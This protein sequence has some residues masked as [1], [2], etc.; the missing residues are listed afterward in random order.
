MLSTIIARRAIARSN[1]A[2]LSSPSSPL[3]PSFNSALRN[4]AASHPL[5]RQSLHTS[6]CRPFRPTLNYRLSTPVPGEHPQMNPIVQRRQSFGK[7]LWLVGAPG[8]IKWPI[9]AIY[10]L[11]FSSGAVLG[12]ILLWDAST[13]RTRYVDGVPVNPLAMNPARGGPKNLKIAEFLVG[14][15]ESEVSEILKMSRLLTLLCANCSSMDMN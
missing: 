8:W 4:V 14:D 11:I 10:A 12:G 9:R 1:L 5:P 6:I 7:K 2:K 3:Y 15:E 13:Y